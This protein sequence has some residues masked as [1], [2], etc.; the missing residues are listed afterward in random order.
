MAPALEVG[1]INF[2]EEVYVDTLAD[3]LR[4]QKMFDSRLVSHFQSQ[5]LNPGHRLR[6]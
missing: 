2:K 5:N 4:A 1:V 6:G 3:V